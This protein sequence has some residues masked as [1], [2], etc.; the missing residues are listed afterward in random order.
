ME[1][2]RAYIIELDSMVPSL[3]A[4]QDGDMILNAEKQQ[5]QSKLWFGFS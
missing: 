5:E 1:N 4:W 2:R 3:T